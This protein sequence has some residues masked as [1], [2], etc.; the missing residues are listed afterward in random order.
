MTFLNSLREMLP[1]S[2]SL[3]HRAARAG[4]WGM[5]ELGA[6]Q[7]L[8]LTSN[9]V[10]TRFLVPEA[11]G[12][13]AMVTTLITAMNLFTD[14]GIQQSVIRSK[15]GEET[16][17]LCVAWSVQVLRFII[18][19]MLVLIAGIILWLLG[20]SLAPTGTVYA[21]PD[22]P[23]LIMASSIAVIFQGL[24]SNNQWLATRR[25]EYSRITMLNIGSQIISLAAM[26]GFV[27][28]HPTVW[29]LLSGMLVG[30]GVRMILTHLVLQ[31][32]RMTF[33]WDKEIADEL[34][35]FGKWLIG[36]SSFTF[37]ASNAD[38]VILGA[39]LDKQMFGNYVIATLWIGAAT[40]AIQK[41]TGGIALPTLSEI[42]RNRPDNIGRVFQKFSRI[43]E[44]ICIIAFL[45][46]FMGGPVLISMLYPST[47]AP[48]ASFMPFLALL[49]LHQRFSILGSL[50]LI[51]GDSK[52]LMLYQGISA[53]ALCIF[54]PLGYWNIGLEGSLLALVISPLV[55]LPLLIQ[56][57]FAIRDG[58]IWGDVLWGVG[59]L[60]FAVILY[61]FL[62]L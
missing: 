3:S 42:Y 40:M 35:H 55:A 15:K 60:A 13:M 26:F 29:A 28:I 39:L 59:I 58:R 45:V 18:I 9:L 34:W 21:D 24:G 14:I 46:A 4:A 48:A 30:S 31:G 11:F 51:R 2:G 17:F 19:A 50:L 62:P 37:I 25:L 8:R 56:R 20:P 43:V 5:A 1:S 49:I 41:I 23:F 7:A 57:T 52:S 38:R 16:H 61:F 33:I 10:M 47:Y 27:S 22:L 54:L 12:V 36:S 44:V 6:S 32:P 53:V